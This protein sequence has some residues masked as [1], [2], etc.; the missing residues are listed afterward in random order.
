[1]LVLGEPTLAAVTRIDVQDVEPRNVTCR[2]AYERAGVTPP[3]LVQYVV[4]VGG[5]FEPARRRRPFV[6][7]AGEAWQPGVDK[8]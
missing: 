7:A 4:I 8:C 5:V 2:D 1:M 6:S 3:Q